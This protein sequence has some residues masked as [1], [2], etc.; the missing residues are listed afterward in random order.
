MS[1]SAKR[2]N[3]LTSLCI[4]FV[5]DVLDFGIGIAERNRVAAFVPTFRI[6]TSCDGQNSG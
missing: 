3:S 2:H 5:E 6:E 4:E 1:L